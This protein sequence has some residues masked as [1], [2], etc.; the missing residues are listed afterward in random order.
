MTWFTVEKPLLYTYILTCVGLTKLLISMVSLLPDVFAKV[1]CSRYSLTMHLVIL[2]EHKKKVI[3]DAILKRLEE[4]FHA[5]CMKWESDIVKFN[6]ESD[7]IHLIVEYN[8]KVQI[9]KLVNNLKQYL[10]V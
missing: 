6:G 2:T 1:R 5:T 8:P 10:A 7:N 4:I 3:S 9:S